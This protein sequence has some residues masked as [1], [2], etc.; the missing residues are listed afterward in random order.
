MAYLA[1][2]PHRLPEKLTAMILRVLAFAALACGAWAAISNREV[3]VKVTGVTEVR[4]TLAEA[5]SG[6]SLQFQL[7]GEWIARGKNPR[8]KITKAVDDSGRELKE[9]KVRRPAGFNSTR[10][11]GTGAPANPLQAQ[12]EV[13]IETP[14][15]T[16]TR[17]REITGT[18]ELYSETA[19]P[20][21]K[22]T[23]GGWAA[24]L[25]H[26]LESPALDKAGISVTLKRTSGLN[27]FGN[28]QAKNKALTVTVKG[29]EDGLIAIYLRKSGKD[30]QPNGTST[31]TTGK[32][33]I[34][35]YTFD[36]APEDADLMLLV[37]SDKAVLRTNFTLKDIDLP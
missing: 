24:L 3:E 2:G 5:P 22:L 34:R 19:D 4:S 10:A 27:L 20:E 31:S 36:P 16:A 18:V 12:A 7:S 1:G 32:E 17:L 11:Y 9:R 33:V 8:I 26:P 28:G 35:E 29:K 13:T 15:R 25:D 14:A 37:A 21:A 30:Q 6:L 23:I